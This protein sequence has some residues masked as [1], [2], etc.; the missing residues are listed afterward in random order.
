MTY[1]IIDE[2][3]DLGKNGSK[4][5][6]ILGILIENEKELDKIIKSLR[7]NKF[8]KTLSKVREIKGT[9]CSSTII[10]QILR[11]IN[12][13]NIKTYCIVLNKD[14][15][16]IKNKNY[17]YDCLAG[18]LAEQ[19]KIDS[20]LIV[21]IDKSK[22]NEK[23]ISDFNK[24]FREKLNINN[25]FKVEIHHSLSHKYKS[26]QIADV[27]AWS[28]FQKFEK[29]NPEFVDLIHYKNKF[30]KMINNENRIIVKSPKNYI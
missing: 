8:K 13:L 29:N 17:V 15:F 4:Y 3:G 27:L 6:I 28:Y 20:S 7:R 22:S 19:I 26:I 2:S 10:K 12:N 24:L 25:E 16:P 23:E 14:E 30:E 21:R 1:L 9:K 5:F 18:V 11:K